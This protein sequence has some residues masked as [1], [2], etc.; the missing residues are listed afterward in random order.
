LR[1]IFIDSHS[2][3]SDRLLSSFNVCAD[4][5]L[6]LSYQVRGTGSLL[7]ENGSHVCVLGVGMVNLKL[8]SG[9]TV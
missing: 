6:F 1:R 4:I 9:R 5:S 7:M 2:P 8:T 3:S